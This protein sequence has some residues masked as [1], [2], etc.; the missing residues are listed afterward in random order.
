[1]SAMDFLADLKK[2]I[3]STKS[4]LLG[5]YQGEPLK[6]TYA[7]YSKHWGRQ[8]SFTSF[9]TWRS[10]QKDVLLSPTSTRKLPCQ[11]LEISTAKL[12]SWTR[13]S[14]LKCDSPRTNSCLGGSNR[15]RMCSQCNPFSS[16]KSLLNIHV[17]GSN[18]SI[19]QRKEQTSPTTITL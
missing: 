17:S 14:H 2:M 5:V 9:A 8:R 19:Q 6:R 3:I 7:I 16:Q 18:T 15:G 4:F 10:C 1:M 12:T 13:K 11:L